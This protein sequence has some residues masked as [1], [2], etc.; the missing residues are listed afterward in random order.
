MNLSEDGKQF[1]KAREQLRLEAYQDEIGVWTIAWGH[2]SGVKAGDVCTIEQAEAWFA[3][4]VAPREAC[5][6]D[7]V[8]VPLTQGQFDALCSFTFNLGCTALR[9]STLLKL[10]N[11]G[12]AAG[13]AEQFG[14]WNHAGGEVS[15]GLTRRR[16]QEKE[17]FL[18]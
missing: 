10:L 18:A 17:T 6:N 5:V 9:N 4:D 3:Q 12:D 13:A 8:K 1:I 2:I 15:A 7:L 14:R 11:A 16:E